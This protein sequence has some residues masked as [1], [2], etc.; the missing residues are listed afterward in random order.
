MYF[1]AQPSLYADVVYSV[2]KWLSF[3]RS[4]NAHV[5][6]EYLQ[7]SIEFY[8]KHK[9]EDLCKAYFTLGNCKDLERLYIC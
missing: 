1:L 4:E 5:V 2:G 6:K 8:G 3:T 9:K 7:N